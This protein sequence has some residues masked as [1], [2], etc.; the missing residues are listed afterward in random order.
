MAGMEERWIEKHAIT[1]HRVD[2]FCMFK[3][4]QVDAWVKAGGAADRKMKDSNE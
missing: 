1:S 4:D 2:R 3:K